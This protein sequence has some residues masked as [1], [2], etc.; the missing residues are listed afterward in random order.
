MRQFDIGNHF[1]EFA[2]NS[3]IQK[4]MQ[5]TKAIFL[6]PCPLGLDISNIDYR[7]FPNEEFQKKWIK[8]YFEA[9]AKI[10]G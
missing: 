6:F 10:E 9:V 5:E 2:G 3:H 7:R 1:C 8:M 4:H